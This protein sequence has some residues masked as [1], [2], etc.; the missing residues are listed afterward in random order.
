MAKNLPK[1]LIFLSLFFF[2]SLNASETDCNQFEKLSPEYLECNAKKLKEK[3]DENI[4]IGKKKIKESKLIKKIK[5][6]KKSKT[7]SDLM[8]K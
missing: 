1:V 7:L 6:F 2:L 5:K 3:T 4:N 8:E